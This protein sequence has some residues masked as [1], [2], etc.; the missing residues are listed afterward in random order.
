MKLHLSKI[1]DVELVNNFRDSSDITQIVINGK[2]ST[3]TL[4]AV[5][6]CNSFSWFE[7][8]T[9]INEMKGKSIVKFKLVSDVSK[10]PDVENAESVIK[11]HLSTIYFSDGT[12]FKFYLKNASNGYY[13][14]WIDIKFE[15]TLFSKPIELEL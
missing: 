10:L 3:M 8:P 9:S 6:E 15:K 4:E 5:G 1:S 7:F 12:E 2:N 11:N 13:D 14:G